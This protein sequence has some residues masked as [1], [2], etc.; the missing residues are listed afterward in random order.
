MFPTCVL[1]K[2]F[3]IDWLFLSLSGTGDGVWVPVPDAVPHDQGVG[4]EIP[5]RRHKGPHLRQGEFLFAIIG[6]DGLGKGST[7][8]LFNPASPDPQ[9]DVELTRTREKQPRASCQLQSIGSSKASMKVKTASHIKNEGGKKKWKP[10]DFPN[11]VSW[12][13]ERIEEEEGT[14]GSQFEEPANFLL[15]PT[16]SFLGKKY[17]FTFF[18]II[19]KFT[20]ACTGELVLNTTLFFKNIAFCIWLGQSPS[21]SFLPILAFPLRWLC[22]ISLFRSCQHRYSSSF[23]SP[24]CLV[25]LRPHTQNNSPCHV[26]HLLFPYFF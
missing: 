11:E 5:Y 6:S 13:G 3:S 4:G 20:W 23:P 14:A 22:P 17:S 25:L 24:V 9:N 7:L 16:R 18:F 8:K 21:S 15:F 12:G 2:L 26:L 10:I 1:F 19:Y